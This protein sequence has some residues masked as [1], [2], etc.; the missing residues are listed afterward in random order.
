MLLPNEVE[1]REP[2]VSPVVSFSFPEVM[3]GLF[4]GALLVNI[5]YTQLLP[6]SD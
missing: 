6:A 5:F 1:G 3:A 2:P 4:C